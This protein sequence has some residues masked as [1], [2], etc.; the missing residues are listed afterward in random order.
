[1]EQRLRELYLRTGKLMSLHVDLLYACDLDCTHC[2]LDDKR[3]RGLPFDRL[4]RVFAE[5]R[6]LGALKLTLSGGEVFLR[7]DLFDLV[8]EAR[9]LRLSVRLKT[10]GGHVDERRARRLASLGVQRVDVSVYAL[11]DRVHDAITRR[12]GSLQRTLRGIE[13]MRQAGVR[14]RVNCSVMHANRD[15]IE[16]L[17]RYFAGRDV[18]VALDGSIR[19]T[20]GGGLEPYAQAL[21]MDDR[22]AMEVFRAESL[23]Q[24]PAVACIEPDERMCF[25]GVL[26][27]YVQPD[28]A[29]TPCVAWPMPVGNV[30]ETSLVDIWRD[31]PGLV[32]VRAARRRD[33]EGCSGCTFEKACLF[34]PGKAWVEQADWKRAFSLQCTDT[35]ARVYAAL[36]RNAQR[37]RA[38]RPRR[39]ARG[40]LRILAPGALH[41]GP[42]SRRGASPRPAHS[43]AAANGA[44]PGRAS[45]GRASGRFVVLDD[46]QAA[47]LRRHAV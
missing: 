41:P 10:H 12:P 5:A 25:A 33:R 22:V 27:V 14:V 24:A 46:R 35:A 23:G 29:V 32:A 43:A 40:R 1:M 15:H 42:R 47:A 6:E 3:P 30:C 28:G 7:R 34:C 9:R 45:G 44:V 39:D 16:A 4:V 21:S 13:A 20:N 38:G 19:G 26:G 11:D 2:Y 8:E 18:E 17:W 37:L 36:A 31:A